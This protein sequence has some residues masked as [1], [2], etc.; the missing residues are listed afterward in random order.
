MFVFNNYSPKAR[1]LQAHLWAHNF[2]YIHCKRYSWNYNWL[3]LFNHIYRAFQVFNITCFTRAFFATFLF[4]FKLQYYCYYLYTKN[5]R[6]RYTARPLI[7]TIFNQGMATCFA[8][9]QTG[10]GKTYVSTY[11]YK[12]RLALHWF[13]YWYCQCQATFKKARSHERILVRFSL[14]RMFSWGSTHSSHSLY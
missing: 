7:E 10:S 3:W 2:V 1:W 6:C 13:P 12:A 11:T 14:S 9:G 4:E 8:Y 5:F